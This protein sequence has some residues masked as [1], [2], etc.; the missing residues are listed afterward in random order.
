VGF[1][2]RVPGVRVSTSGVRVGPRMANVRVG[3]GG[4]S[5]SV[6][7]RGARLRVSN[8]GVSVGSGIGPIGV[9]TRGGVNLQGSV[10]PVFGSV[11]RR[12]AVLGLGVGPIMAAVATASSGANSANVGTSGTPTQTGIDAGKGRIRATANADYKSYRSSLEREGV[13]RRRRS[14]MRVAGVHAALLQIPPFVAAMQ[15][16]PSFS[17]VFPD[18]NRLRRENR[19]VAETVFL[20][21]ID[22]DHEDEVFHTELY[23]R[24]Q[25]IERLKSDGV[26]EPEQLTEIVGLRQPVFESELEAIYLERER[27][28][29]ESSLRRRVFSRKSIED[30]AQRRGESAW[31]EQRQA[32]RASD[33]A[34]RAA[35]REFQAR[36][37]H[38]LEKQKLEREQKI[39]ARAA[40]ELAQR[41]A[42]EERTEELTRSQ[43][44]LVQ[45][46]EYSRRR[47]F[48]LDPTLNLIV[49][50]AAFSDNDGTAA[51]VGVDGADLLVLMTM[52]GIE[53]VIWPEIFTGPSPTSVTKKSKPEQR[54]EYETYLKCHSVAAAREAFALQPKLERV[55]VIALEE[56][57]T[58][59]NDRLLLSSLTI[60][61]SAGARMGV[62]TSADE[63]AVMHFASAWSSALYES[64]EKTTLRLL[65]Q[66][67]QSTGE[68]F[69]NLMRNWRKELDSACQQFSSIAGMKRTF[70]RSSD[71]ILDSY[72]EQDGRMAI[73]PDSDEIATLDISVDE[74]PTPQ[75]WMLA[76]FLAEEWDRPM[77]NIEALRMR[78]NQAGVILRIYSNE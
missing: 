22:R 56:S 15:T 31:N 20:G 66:W 73:D 17:P 55:R 60:D 63:M 10:G 65:D 9:N 33:D 38:E 37:N 44:P 77:V 49:F 18:I 57:E 12:G 27:V 72:S 78:A 8:R 54:S 75:F 62:R 30:E 11:S 32:I 39:E 51:P 43:T 42:I 52:P 58:S 14:E 35:S 48:E 53:D 67:D 47:F 64:D 71:R 45:K 59:L 16:F 70:G 34:W 2:I 13:T 5:G 3:R 21:H 69:L 28:V 40:H 50:S 7:P 68:Q 19:Q 76:T 6:G 74:L 24:E 26:V 41:S 46:L 61:R 29:S 36:V 1:G 4:V 23:Q 25:I